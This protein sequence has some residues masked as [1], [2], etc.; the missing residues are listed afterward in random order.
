MAS[1]GPE[2]NVVTGAF[3]FTGKYITQRLLSAGKRVRTLTGHPDRPNPFGAQVSAAP[4]N[5]DSFSEL[6]KSLDGAT[7][8]YNTY[9]IRFPYGKVTFE[10]A[11]ENTR[12]LIR[13]AEEA[14]VRRIVHVS[15]THASVDCPFPYFRGKG[16]VEEAIRHSRLS[17]A[18]LRPTVIFGHG[19]ILINNIAWFF[20]RF[21]VFAIPG[22]GD[23]QVQP[24]Y[25][26]DVAELAVRVGQQEEDLTVDTVGPETYTYQDLVLL[27]ARSLQ[28][29]A[30]VV[31]LPPRLAYFA[32][33]LLGYLVRDV[34]L[35][36]EEVQ[37]LMA[38]L[39]VSAEPP[40]GQTRLSQR[41]GQ[42]SETV[43][44]RYASELQRHYR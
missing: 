23:Y 8:L 40:T 3:G 16:L 6:V 42:H 44:R 17:Y 38:G 13:A 15:I 10:K 28:R 26:E 35:T 32:V 25:V 43:G 31:H 19:D 30:R 34:I 27:I 33:G 4:Y 36:W 11:V 18:I 5:F 37:G 22:R 2:L 41:L 14:G 9:W 39:L 7:T 21:P 24:V 12:I 1:E 29:R 20:R